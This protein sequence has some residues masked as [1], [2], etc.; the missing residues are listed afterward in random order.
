MAVDMFKDYVNIASTGLNR[1]MFSGNQVGS[2][3]IYDRNRA[4]DAKADMPANNSPFAGLMSKLGQIFGKNKKGSYYTPGTKVTPDNTGSV[5]SEYPTDDIDYSNEEETIL[6]D[7]GDP[8]SVPANNETI[9][10]ELGNVVGA[11]GTLFPDLDAKKGM[12][13][14]IPD[15]FEGKQ[16]L[17][18]DY[19]Q[20]KQGL[21]P[22][23]LPSIGWDAAPEISSKL[24]KGIYDTKNQ[25]GDWLYNQFSLPGGKSAGEIEA[26]QYPEEIPME[27]YMKMYGSSESGELDENTMYNMEQDEMYDNY[28]DEGSSSDTDFYGTSSEPGKS[29]NIGFNPNSDLLSM[30]NENINRRKKGLLGALKLRNM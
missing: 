9:G 4:A 28:L 30:G 1:D 26:M 3:S 29:Y 7:N 25:L 11:A 18:P 16:G 13:G 20:G 17:I 24:G 12:S 27:E 22:D 8:V 15:Y 21:F 6:D 23:Y 5:F 14:Y 2:S 19:F 10:G